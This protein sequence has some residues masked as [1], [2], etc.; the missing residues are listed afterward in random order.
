[1]AQAAVPAANTIVCD[2]ALL[3]SPLIQKQATDAV[4]AFTEYSTYE[5][6][7]I[8][9]PRQFS[10]ADSDL[11]MRLQV[12]AIDAGAVS[13]MKRDTIVNMAAWATNDPPRPCLHINFRPIQRKN[14][15]YRAYLPLSLVEQDNHV[16][17]GVCVT[18]LSR[19]SQLRHYFKF[20]PL[21]VDEVLGKVL[22]RYIYAAYVPKILLINLGPGQHWKLR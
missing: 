6:Y 22:N 21:E 15:D 19:V 14:F 5:G 18:S 3:L 1:M 4:V 8:I 16:V 11:L 9:V 17:A 13:S 7:T 2:Q 12:L 10:S 20:I